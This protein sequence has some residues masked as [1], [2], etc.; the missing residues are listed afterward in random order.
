MI[1][2][3]ADALTALSPAKFQRKGLITASADMPASAAVPK[4]HIV[5]LVAA[6]SQQ[7]AGHP[8]PFTPYAIQTRAMLAGMHTA[9]ARPGQDSI[10]FWATCTACILR[11]PA[12]ALQAG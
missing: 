10:E 3:S 11:A 9:A 12:G 4:A 7:Q 8:L 2:Q 1:E 6:Y 5:S